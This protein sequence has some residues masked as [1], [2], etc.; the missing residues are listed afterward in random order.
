MNVLVSFVAGCCVALAVTFLAER[1]V[2]SYVELARDVLLYGLA[3]AGIA[4]ALVLLFWKRVFNSLGL[5]AD[6]ALKQVAAPAIS[7]LVAA[8]QGRVADAERSASDALAVGLSWYTQVQARRWIVA[9]LVGLLAA[10]AA[11]LGSVLLVKQNRLLQEQTRLINTQ[12][13]LSESQRRAALV[14]EL[15]SILDQIDEELDKRGH[16]VDAVP[17]RGFSDAPGSAPV[18]ERPRLRDQSNPVLF[19]LSD[20]LTGRIVAISRSLRPYRY[21]E[22]DGALSNIILSPERAQLLLSLINSGVDLEDI[23]HANPVFDRA[24]LRGS[25]LAQNQLQHLRLRESDLTKADLRGANLEYGHFQGAQF[26]AAVLEGAAMNADFNGACFR[27]ANLRSAKLDGGRLR[28]ADLGGAY[29]KGASLE[30]ADFSHADFSGAKGLSEVSNWSDARLYAVRGMDETLLKLA[31]SKG[32]TREPVSE[33]QAHDETLPD[34]IGCVVGIQQT[35][36]S[37]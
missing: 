2:E 36:R 18:V 20:R 5:R 3:I 16:Q 24:D 26:V 15:S 25:D 33:P 27:G 23:N 29:L 35:A 21:L 13:Y 1:Y 30:G 28:F 32:A 19:R 6:A 37:R 10:F 34:R 22:D 31:V 4:I 14:F 8:G 7:S 11:L 17:T 12:N 9:T